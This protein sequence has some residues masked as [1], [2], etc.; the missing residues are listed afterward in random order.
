MSEWSRAQEAEFQ[1]LVH[2]ASEQSREY[3]R[4]RD[5][6]AE[7]APDSPRTGREASSNERRD[8]RV[9]KCS[10]PPAIVYRPEL[11]CPCTLPPPPPPP[12]PPPPPPPPPSHPPRKEGRK[13]ESGKGVAK[14]LSGILEKLDNESIMLMVLLWLLVEEK[15]DNYLILAIAYILLV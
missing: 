12:M 14:G 13:K 7:H 10:P 9:E 2:R 6:Y 3:Y 8:N 15:A 4:R 1:Q 5:P 11:P